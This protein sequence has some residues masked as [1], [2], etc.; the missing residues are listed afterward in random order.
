MPEV[1]FGLKLVRRNWTGKPG[2]DRG[3]PPSLHH[4]LNRC[5]AITPSERRVANSSADTASS[6]VKT[7]S[8]CWPKSG[9]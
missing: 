6:S 2:C 3:D 1:T 9:A 4:W 7:S 5:Q 8:V